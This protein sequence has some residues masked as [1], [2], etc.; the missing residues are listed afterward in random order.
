MSRLNL[1]FTQV[2]AL[3]MGLSLLAMALA[4]SATYYWD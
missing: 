1:S 3:L 2:R 4:G